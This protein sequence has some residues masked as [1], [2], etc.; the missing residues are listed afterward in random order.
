MGEHIV[1]KLANLGDDIADA[2][3][4]GED[5]GA[6]KRISTG[7]NIFTDVKG[8]KGY[9]FEPYCTMVF[10]CNTF[11]R[12]KDTTDGF[13]RRLFPIEFNATFSPDDEDYDPMITEKLMDEEVLE[14][15]CVLGVSSLKPALERNKPTPNRYSA[16][17]KKSIAAESNTA[18]QWITDEGIRPDDVI[19]KTKD[20]VYTQYVDWCA[21]NGYSKTAIASG[22]LIKFLNG[23]RT[24][25]TFEKKAD[26]VPFG[27]TEKEQ[28]NDGK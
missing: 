26:S 4:D 2:Y 7:E 1:G 22:T 5:C 17:V 8:T 15:A 3:L 19:G 28:V 12:C 24:V 25:K 16:E 6:I 9:Y 11:P 14:A 20:E 13:M 23:R 10:S 18:L 21:R 27:A